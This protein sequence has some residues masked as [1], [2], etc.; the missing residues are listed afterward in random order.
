MNLKNT[1]TPIMGFAAFLILLFH[2]MPIPRG[3]DLPSTLARFIIMTA[4]IGVDMFFFMSAY[5]ARF[6]DTEKYGAYIKRKFINI[7]PLFILSCLIAASLGQLKWPKVLPTLLGLELFTKGGGSFLWFAPSIMIFYLLLPLYHKMI[8]K[9]GAIKSCLMSL[10]VWFI[11]MVVLEK[12]LNNHNI[13]IFLARIPILLIGITLASYEGKWKS[14]TKLLAALPLLILGI[15]LNWQFGFMVK[16]NFLFTDIFYV[17]TIPFTLG[18]IL[19]MD[20]LFSSYK[21]IFLKHLGKIS[22]ELYCLQM[23]LGVYFIR[24]FARNMSSKILLF[25][26]VFLCLTLLSF[27]LRYIRLRLKPAKATPKQ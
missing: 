21:T 2:L 19:L 17:L 15:F 13:N 16:A 25:L 5:M 10:A 4:Y 3:G 18:L 1:R 9:L 26:L 20:V 27:T 24:L 7:Y 11:L 14:R 8:D 12:L 23:A 6:S 22:Y